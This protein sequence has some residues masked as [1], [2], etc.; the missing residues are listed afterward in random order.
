MKHKLGDKDSIRR[1][2]EHAHQAKVNRA[3]IVNKEV[4]NLAIDEAIK[5]VY[6]AIG[7]ERALDGLIADL[8]AL[9]ATEEAA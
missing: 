9:K 3:K 8:R 1:R 6:G 5:I 7:D 4:W 2:F